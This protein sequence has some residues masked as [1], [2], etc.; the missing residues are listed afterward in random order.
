MAGGEQSE[1]S[2]KAAWPLGASVASSA[3][4]GQLHGDSCICYEDKCSGHEHRQRWG[5][6]IWVRIPHQGTLP[7]AHG[8]NLRI[9]QSSFP[10][11]C[12][13]TVN[14]LSKHTNVAGVRCDQPGQMSRAVH[15]L[16]AQPLGPS[17]PCDLGTWRGLQ[18]APGPPL[19]DGGHTTPSSQHRKCNQ[20][21]EEL[22]TALAR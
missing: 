19:R 11:R 9:T 5:Q 10:S 18:K 1:L 21:Y 3:R 8:M 14:K 4:R 7:P 17:L 6:T 13:V 12:C 15:S 20:A 16:D 22:S 2:N